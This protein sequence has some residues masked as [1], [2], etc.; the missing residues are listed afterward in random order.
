MIGPVAG[1]YYLIEETRPTPE[2]YTEVA[3]EFLSHHL[4]IEDEYQIYFRSNN[5]ET[6]LGYAIYFT[7]EPV[8]GL[9][10]V[11]PV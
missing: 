1:K 3:S 2:G 4:D 9:R 7:S 8:E 6:T 11:T 10:I 5:K